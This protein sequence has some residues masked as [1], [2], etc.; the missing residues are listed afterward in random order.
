[1]F[2]NPSNILIFD[3]SNLKVRFCWIRLIKFH[4][5]I[6]GGKRVRAF[7]NSCGIITLSTL[8]YL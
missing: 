8:N 5:L 2:G 4:W 1:M 3:G 7:I 6:K